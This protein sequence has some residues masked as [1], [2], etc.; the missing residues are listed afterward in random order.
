MINPSNKLQYSLTPLVKL[1][2]KL[3]ITIL[4]AIMPVSGGPQLMLNIT[5]DSFIV[6]MITLRS[7]GA[8]GN[9][10]PHFS[11]LAPLIS[12]QSIHIT[13]HSFTDSTI[14]S[15]EGICTLYL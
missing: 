11:A 15:L 7:G 1:V 8:L 3:S 2:F 13:L 5:M 6:V 4:Y 14:S 10:G 12:Q 9:F